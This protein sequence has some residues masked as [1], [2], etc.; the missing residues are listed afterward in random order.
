[1]LSKVFYL[2]LI[3]QVPGNKT[4]Q[5]KMGELS[6]SK[7]KLKFQNGFQNKIENFRIT[8]QTN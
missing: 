4:Y 2:I 3:K 7:M 8:L 1:M 6:K 5:K